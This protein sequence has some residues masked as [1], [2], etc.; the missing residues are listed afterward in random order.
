MPIARSKSPAQLSL[1]EF[2]RKTPDPSSARD[3]IAH[4]FLRAYLSYVAISATAEMGE[5]SI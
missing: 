1:L 3:A 2:L 5:T 4:F